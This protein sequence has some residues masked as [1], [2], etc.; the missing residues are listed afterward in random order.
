MN[1]RISRST[2]INWCDGIK[3]NLSRPAFD[4]AWKKIKK[5]AKGSFEELRHLEEDQ[6]KSD[7]RIWQPWLQRFKDWLVA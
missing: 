1:G 5:E 4:K 6:F 3:T 7:P 2:W